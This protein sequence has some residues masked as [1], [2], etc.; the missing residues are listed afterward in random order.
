MMLSV[1]FLV[2]FLNP[3]YYDKWKGYRNPPPF[4]PTPMLVGEDG[5]TGDIMDLLL[6]LSVVY[7]CSRRV[8]GSFSWITPD[9]Y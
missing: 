6:E 8:E 3:P 2:S 4:Q 7:D 1:L 5:L 9:S